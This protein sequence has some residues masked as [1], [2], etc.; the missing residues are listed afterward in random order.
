MSTP[1]DLDDDNMDCEII[2]PDLLLGAY[3]SGIFPMSE[4]ASDDE[5]FWVDPE[6]R[7]ILPL[8]EFYLSKRLR[9]TLRQQPFEIRINTA[10]NET[11]LACQETSK[12]RSETWI[13]ELIV[14]SYRA[15][16]DAGHAHSVECWDGD[17]MVGGL[18]GVSLEGAFF[19]ESM[20]SRQTDASKIALAY[21][22]ARLKHG[23]YRLL[24]CQFKTDHLSQFGVVEVP[25]GVY[26]TQLSEALEVDG[27]FYS[28]A[29]N[30]SPLDVLQIIGQ[31]S[32]TGC[33]SA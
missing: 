26:H 11:I 4:R 22:V 9:R 28:L 16:H 13:N 32:K 18:Y 3:A 1:N 31:T 19:G 30:V 33:S 23:G 15:L 6:W 5:I 17:K 29:V 25:R 12:A 7:G 8:D 24:D 27:D 2:R 10:F 21:L 14:N 20:F